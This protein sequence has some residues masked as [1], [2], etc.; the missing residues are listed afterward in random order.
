MQPA[1]QE[2]LDAKI[3]QCLSTNS[4]TNFTKQISSSFN[5]EQKLKVENLQSDNPSLHEYL[6]HQLGM[7]FLSDEEMSIAQD[8]ISHIDNNGYLRLSLEK[9]IEGRN[10][11]LKQAQKVLI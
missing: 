1:N 3:K 7:T 8:L 6:L 10:I 11:T 5:G 4:Q 2:A 9:F